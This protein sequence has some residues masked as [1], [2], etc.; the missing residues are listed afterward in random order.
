LSCVLQDFVAG[1]N[2]INEM[3]SFK[4]TTNKHNETKQHLTGIK[5]GASAKA[6]FEK[7]I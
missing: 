6:D 4:R 1:N 3:L 2:V 7:K 5:T